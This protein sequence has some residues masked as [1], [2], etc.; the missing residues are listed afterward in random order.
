MKDQ[1]FIA[2]AI[3]LARKSPEP[4]GCGVVIVCNG[5]VISE[6]CSSQRVDNI[7]VHHAEIKTIVTAKN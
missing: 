6:A 2:S 3:E 5:K 7:A 1:A 4:I